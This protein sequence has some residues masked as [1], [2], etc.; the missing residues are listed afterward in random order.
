M[1]SSRPQPEMK[2]TGR[3]VSSGILVISPMPSAPGNMGSSSTSRGR[4]ARMRPAFSPGSAVCS[5]YSRFPL[6]LPLDWYKSRSDRRCAVREPRRVQAEFGAD[7]DADR[8]IR[9]HD[10]TADMRSM[11]RPMRPASRKGMSEEALAGLVT[12]Y[13]LIGVT[14]PRAR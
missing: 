8:R 6:G 7:I 14:E 1:V 3:S 5:C 10:S 12:R 2:T 9:V 11:I 13:S 4:S